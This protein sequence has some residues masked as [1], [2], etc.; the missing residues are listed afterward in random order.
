MASQQV[1][2]GNEINTILNDIIAG[3]T[4]MNKLFVLADENTSQLVV[5]QL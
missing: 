3:M 2:F 5:P 4:K 1:I